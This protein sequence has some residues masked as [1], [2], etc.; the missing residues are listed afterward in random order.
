MRASLRTVADVVTEAADPRE[1]LRAD[2]ARTDERLQALDADV[3][4]IVEATAGANT[5]DEH[6]PEGATIAF[7]RAQLL[8]LAAAARRHLAE[9]D[10]ALDRLAHGGYGRC[11]RCGGAIPTARL[12]ARP[13]ARRCVPCA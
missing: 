1:A 6:D 10:A 4:R 12:E 3:A 9:V 11:E 8:A 7:E 5:D 13:D 2:R